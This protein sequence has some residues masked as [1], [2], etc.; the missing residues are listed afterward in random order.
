MEFGWPYVASVI[1]GITLV[2]PFKRPKAKAGTDDRAWNTDDKT[3][4]E[5]RF[6]DPRY[7]YF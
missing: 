1:A 3:W 5:S 6:D 2:A 4:S 7:D